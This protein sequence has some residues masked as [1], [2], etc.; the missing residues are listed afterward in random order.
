MSINNG[1]GRPRFMDTFKAAMVPREPINLDPS[2]PNP[3]P[4][5]V[6]IAAAFSVLAGAASVLTGALYITTRQSTV[7]GLYR[8]IQDCND[9]GIGIGDAVTATTPEDQVTICK[10]IARIPTDEDISSFMSSSLMVGIVLLVVGIGAIAGGVYL[11][12]GARW[13]RRV[14]TTVGALLL[15]GTMLG[16]F[17]GLL[18]LVASLLVLIGLAMLYVGKGATYFIRAKAQGIR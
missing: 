13:A 11:F 9:Q 10:G 2:A 12:K 8:A 4:R 16:L 18:L 6:K 14:V 5:T 15:V 3:I 17:G 7:D 1:S